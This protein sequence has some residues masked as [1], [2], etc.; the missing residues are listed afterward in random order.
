MATVPLAV[1]QNTVSCGANWRVFET[2]LL[3]LVFV[4]RIIIMMSGFNNYRI[5]L[6]LCWGV[7]SP[8][9]LFPFT[10]HPYHCW[11]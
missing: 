3:T 8:T 9:V 1:I 5:V 6:Q 11:Y 10:A 7:V 4:H 2:I